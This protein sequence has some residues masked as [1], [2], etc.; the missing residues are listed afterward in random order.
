MLKEGL[1]HTS[2]TRVSQDNTA[3]KMGSGDMEVFA[4]PAMVALMENAA[5]QAVSPFLPEGSSTVGSQ[6]DISHTKPSGVGNKISATAILMSIDSR[7]LTFSVQATDGK[8]TIGQ[9]THIRFIVD[10]TKFLSK[11]K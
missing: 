10:K 4:T 9:G 5:M 3:L 7:K 8:D 6:I 2:T 1:T 11:L